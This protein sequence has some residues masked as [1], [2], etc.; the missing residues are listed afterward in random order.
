M[1]T[2]NKYGG[3]SI[4]KA[5]ALA[6]A[7]FV[8]CGFVLFAGTAQASTANFEFTRNLGV[9]MQGEDV[10]HLQE[11]LEQQGLYN[12]PVSGS[13]DSSM[14]DAVRAFQSKYGIPA[15]G[16][17]GSLTIARLNDLIGQGV[18][19]GASTTGANQAQIAAIRAQL[20][21]LLQQ[22]IALLQAQVQHAS[23]H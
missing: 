18:V 8:V 22:L 21:S 3:Q 7:V 10:I 20:A 6:T 4:A 2:I 17:I 15:T 5:T 9:G 19:L 12:G 11:L 16:Y 1:S 13:F 23:G 14:L